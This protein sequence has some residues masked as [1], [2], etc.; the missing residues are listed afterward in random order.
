MKEEQ[1][2]L[3][4]IWF[5]KF[6]QDWLN[7][8]RMTKR[9]Y[10]LDKPWFMNGIYS[11]SF[12]DW[13][14][15]NLRGVYQEPGCFI[16]AEHDEFHVLE[17]VTDI[18]NIDVYYNV[19]FVAP[20]HFL[21]CPKEHRENPTGEDIINLSCFSEDNDL[22][23]FCNLKD[24]GASYPR[25][26]H[27]QPLSDEGEETMNSSVLPLIRSPESTILPVKTMPFSKVFSVRDVT[28]NV[29]D[30]P[31]ATY[32]WEF[33]GERGRAI[34]SVA[35]SLAPKPYNLMISG[36]R[37]YVFGRKASRSKSL[38]D[39][40]VATAEVCGCFFCR[41]REQFN[42][43]TSERILIGFSETCLMTEQERM[44]FEECLINKTKEVS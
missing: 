27:Y 14:R 38:G 26:V 18:G 36:R 28:L 15:N 35:A 22:A 2:S 32:F 9:V 6:G 39:F 31:I 4:E 19:K 33:E 12:H 1:G 43:L 21:A 10:F 40:K 7:D 11:K 8:F 17:K 34:A 3:R 44:G 30:W 37:I 41:E 16:C 42:D 29:V 23:V 20:C 25:H 24:S 13:S 5:R